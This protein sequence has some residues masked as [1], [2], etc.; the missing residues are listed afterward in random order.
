MSETRVYKSSEAVRRAVKKYRQTHKTTYNAYQNNYYAAHKAKISV[1]R[2]ARRAR[3]KQ[4][5]TNMR[6]KAQVLKQLI[7]I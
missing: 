1:Q 3:K 5:Q 4:I 2:K 7:S 6:L